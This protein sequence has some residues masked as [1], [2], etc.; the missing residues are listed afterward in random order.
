MK[1]AIVGSRSITNADIAKAVP[2]D[3]ELIISGGA[4]GIDTIA[5]KYADA[6]G[7]PKKIFYPDYGL[8]GKSA[9]LIRDRIIVDSAD[10]VIAFWDGHSTGTDYTISYAK[11]RKVP[12]QL[13]MIKK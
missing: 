4:S 10:L 6:H 8:Y 2:P 13:Y 9:P 11:K 5:E 1:V 7:I 12:V 3:T